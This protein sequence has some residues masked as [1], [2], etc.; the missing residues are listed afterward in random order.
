MEQI[1]SVTDGVTE[2]QYVYYDP[3]GGKVTVNYKYDA[4]GRYT[5]SRRVDKPARFNQVVKV[6]TVTRT[7]TVI[8]FLKSKLFH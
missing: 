8:S 2:G 5:E 4:N 7:E 1:Q 6:Q 3:V